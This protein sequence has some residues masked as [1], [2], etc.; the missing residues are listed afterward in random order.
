[1]YKYNEKKYVEHILKNGFSSKHI[2]NEIRLLAIHYK[3]KGMTEEDREKELYD[4]CEKKMQSFDRVEYFKK[5]NSA[6]NH[7]KKLESKLVEVDEIY[8]NKKEL[9]YIDILELSHE[10][11]RIIFTLLSLNKL[12]K[13]IQKQRDPKK[14]NNEHYF[15]GSNKNYK[16]LIDAS[17]VPMKSK[18]IHSIISE[19]A[20]LGIVEIRGNGFIKLSFVYDLE[21]GETVITIKDYEEIGY[22][23]DL[24]KGTNRVKE[25]EECKKPIKVNGKY[26]KYCLACSKEKE[27]IRKKV[28]KKV[29][30]NKGSEV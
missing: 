19:L 18:K 26:K 2:N 6:L 13:E 25:C 5:I 8:I 3:E 22:Y 21:Y 30:K 7:A 23:Y 12:N 29:N 10:Y 27:K 14:L 17:K 24:Y 20:S 9:N 4:F 11:K 28:W 16:E 1:M 15:G